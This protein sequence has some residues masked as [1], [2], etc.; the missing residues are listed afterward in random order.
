MNAAHR[1]EKQNAN[2]L[3]TLKRPPEGLSHAEACAFQAE[4][5]RGI[6]AAYRAR[7]DE[8]KAKRAEDSAAWW[9]KHAKQG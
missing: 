8:G 1:T 2:R 5:Q 3:P 4:Q 9:D 6:A 7:G